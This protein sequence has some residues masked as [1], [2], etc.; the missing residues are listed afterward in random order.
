MNDIYAIVDL[1]GY[2]TEMR[3]AAAKSISTSYEENI[4][5]FITIKQMISIVKENCI[6][7]DDQ[8]RPLLNE[9]TNEMIYESAVSW[10]NGIGL[11]KL[12]GKGFIECAWDDKNNEMIFW[13]NQNIHI[14]ETKK[15]DER[16]NKKK[17]K[18]S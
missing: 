3:N 16:R 17:N 12:A 9:D 2:A 18:G 7:F 14:M 1:E 13:E 6:G 10:I 4:D 8:N 11:A 5:D 15:N